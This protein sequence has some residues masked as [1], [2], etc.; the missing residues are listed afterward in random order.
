MKIIIIMFRQLFIIY[1]ILFV[2]KSFKSDSIVLFP[3][4]YAK[5]QISFINKSLLLE[6][7][8][9]IFHVFEIWLTLI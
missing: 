5:F 3:L 6:A 4:I 9:V 1:I 2:S 8:L 7:S